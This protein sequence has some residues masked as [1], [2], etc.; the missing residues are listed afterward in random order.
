MGKNSQKG[1]RR[2]EG[3][4]GCVRNSRRGK[5]KEEEGRGKRSGEEGKATLISEYLNS[6]SKTSAWCMCLGTKTRKF[7]KHYITPLKFPVVLPMHFV[8]A[9]L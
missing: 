4:G 7:L 3:I 1:K 2:R 6:L 8:S 5:R 9:E